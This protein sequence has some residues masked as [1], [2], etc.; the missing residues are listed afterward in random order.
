MT[1]REKKMNARG[2][3][4]GSNDHSGEENESEWS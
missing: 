3:N 4:R 2:R 1:I